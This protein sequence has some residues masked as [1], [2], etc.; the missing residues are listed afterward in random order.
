MKKII[1]NSEQETFDFAYEYAKNL[2]GGEI[3]GLKGDL[4]SGK[5]VFSKGL[6]AGLGIKQNVTSP[7]FVVMKVYSVENH[8]S[9]KTFCHIDAYRLSG[10]DIESTGIQEYIDDKNTILVIEW[11]DRIKKILPRK[12]RLIKI[13][14]KK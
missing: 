3:I 8:K 7:T 12:T 4:G 14:L 6:A 11:V 1:T 2:K 13:S 5:T 9:I 10:S